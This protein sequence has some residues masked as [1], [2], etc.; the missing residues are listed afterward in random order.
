MS[1]LHN[2][3]DVV[4]EEDDVAASVSSIVKAVVFGESNHSSVTTSAQTKC[5]I[6]TICKGVFVK[7]VMRT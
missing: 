1:Q 4:A 3:V 7:V 5:L 2:R 6:D